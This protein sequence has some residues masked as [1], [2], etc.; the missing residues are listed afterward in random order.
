MSKNK[1]ISVG[2]IG[3]QKC[4]LNIS[5]EEAIKRYCKSENCK[6]ENITVEEFDNNSDID[7]YVIEFEDEFECYSIWE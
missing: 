2:Y 1:I 6:S 7:S 3:L 5:E 4:Y